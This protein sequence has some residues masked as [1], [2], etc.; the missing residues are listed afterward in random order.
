MAFNTQLRR[1]GLIDQQSLVR[2]LSPELML[3]DPELARRARELLHEPGERNGKGNMSTLLG[4]HEI[5]S[6]TV[7]GLEP[8][9]SPPVVHG[10]S[11]MT[12]AGPSAHV[13]LPSPPPALRPPESSMASEP[14]PVP[15]PAQAPTPAPAPVAPAADVAPAQPE[16]ASPA[17]PPPPPPPAAEQGPEPLMAPPLE[18]VAPQAPAPEPIELKPVSPAEELELDV[19]ASAPAPPVEPELELPAMA[20]EPPAAPSEPEVPELVMAPPPPPEPAEPVTPEIP[21]L[22]TPAQV[23]ETPIDLPVVEALAPPAPEPPVAE[24]PVA[25]VEPTLDVPPV[26]SQPGA[27]RVVVRMSDGDGVEVGEFRDFG[28]AMQGAQEVID[29]FSHSNGSWPFY[30]GRFIRPDLIIS[31]DVVDAAAG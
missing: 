17:P 6:G 3:V 12:T 22:V 14:A 16:Q 9:L 13:D 29:Q 11:A 15:E 31:V 19:A 23:E 30:A 21:A 25:V 10:P 18:P 26:A 4:T 20:P 1:I 24:E 5:S 7:L 8:P 27:F 28:T 2:C